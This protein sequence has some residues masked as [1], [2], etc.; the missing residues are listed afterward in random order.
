[1]ILINNLGMG[2]FEDGSTDYILD[3]ER[4][5]QPSRL[6]KLAW[7]LE[8][9][10][11]NTNWRHVTYKTCAISYFSL[12]MWVA[13]CILPLPGHWPKFESIQSDKLPVQ[14]QDYNK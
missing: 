14:Y 12:L 9:A 5:K 11:S 7:M 10:I 1:L 6:I 4:P 2:A 13:W 3:V 8:D